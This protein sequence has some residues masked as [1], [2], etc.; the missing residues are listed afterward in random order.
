MIVRVFVSYL[1]LNIAHLF[2][3]VDLI[4]QQFQIKVDP[5]PQIAL[6]TRLTIQRDL[7]AVFRQPHGIQGLVHRTIDLVSTVHFIVWRQKSK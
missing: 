7:C 5:I 4:C 3:S 6:S 2:F 1:Y